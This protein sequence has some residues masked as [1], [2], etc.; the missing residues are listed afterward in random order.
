MKRY[1]IE[2][3]HTNYILGSFDDL[4][5]ATR[6]YNR[7]SRRKFGGIVLIDRATGE[8]IKLKKSKPRALIIAQE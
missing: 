6:F 3:F 8:V 7:T 4:E 2:N 5:D 1:T